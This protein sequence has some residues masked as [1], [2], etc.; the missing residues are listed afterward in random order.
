[1]LP[2]S[3]DEIL[4]ATMPGTMPPTKRH[5]RNTYS[6]LTPGRWITRVEEMAGEGLTSKKQS[7]SVLNLAPWLLQ[8]FCSLDFW[9]VS[10]LDSASSKRSWAPG[11]PP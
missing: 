4:S 10:G 11:Q 2:W 9:F 6:P 3:Y 7:H 8:T 1:M 5:S